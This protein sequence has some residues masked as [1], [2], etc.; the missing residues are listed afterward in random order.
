[1]VAAIILIAVTVAVSIAVAAW[2]GAL[3]FTF[4]GYESLEI[5]GVT[6]DWSTMNSL[7]ITVNNDGTKDVTLH[8]VEVN[9]VQ[10][11][12]A[13]T[14]PTVLETDDTP[15]DLDITFAYTNGTAYDISVVTS[16]GYEF[17][18]HFT[19]GQDVTPP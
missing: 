4:M 11:T 16:G 15:L 8:H 18:D 7:T 6:W 19:G 2:M 10:K 12:V 17:T 5:T 13:P 3:T 9:Y 14:L 1:M